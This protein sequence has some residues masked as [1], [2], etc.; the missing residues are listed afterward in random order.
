MAR[1]AWSWIDAI[2]SKLYNEGSLP[3]QEHSR[4]HPKMTTVMTYAGAAKGKTSQARQNSG[5]EVLRLLRGV[6]R[7][8]AEAAL[9][10]N[11]PAMIRHRTQ[12]IRNETVVRVTK[13]RADHGIKLPDKP[14]TATITRAMAAQL[15][16]SN[17]A[18]RELR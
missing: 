3:S 18:A 15:A 17:S 4:V 2:F 10:D 9:R 12:I 13:V 14:D 1:H 5:M 16:E 8:E 6:S 11:L 7:G